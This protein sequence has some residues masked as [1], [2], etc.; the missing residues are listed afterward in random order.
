VSGRGFASDNHS[1]VHP[2]VLEAIAAANDGHAPAYGADPW[3]AALAGRFRDH[4]G[5]RAVALPVFNGSGANVVAIAAVSRPWQAVACPQ[6]AHLNVD[7][8]GAP[9]KIAGVKLITVPTPEG[10]LTTELLETAIPWDRIGDEH[11]AQPRVVSISNSTELGTVY[12]AAETRALADFAHQHDLL[13]HVDGARLANAAASLGTGLGDLTADAGAD[14]L[15]FGGTKN[16]LLAGEAVVF[17][18]EGLAAGAEIVRKGSLQLASKMRFFSAQLDAL[19]GP[20][21]L[22]RSNAAHANEMAARLAEA[23]TAVDGVELAHPVQA[24]GVFARFP[25]AAIAGLEFEPDGRRAFYVWDAEG[26]VVRL[27]CSWD[28]TPE[29]VDSFASRLAAVGP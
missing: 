13:L 11:F 24:N 3:T 10:K 4:F 5:P 16:G 21:D 1:G 27:M 9:E 29:D 7:E 26:R 22:W 23:V 18:R 25:A 17:L 20:G 19:L 6:T 2:D 14:V 15:S 28:T 12:D 8:A